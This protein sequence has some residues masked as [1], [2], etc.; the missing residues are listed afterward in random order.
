MIFL[1]ADVE[2]NE[3]CD[4]H[5]FKSLNSSNVSAG[6]PCTEDICVQNSKTT[7]EKS[8]SVN[9]GVHCTEEPE[10][11]NCDKTYVVS[12]TVKKSTDVSGG[13]VSEATVELNTLHL[14]NDDG[15]S[16]ITLKLDEVC[17]DDANEIGNSESNVGK[18]S[19]KNC[20]GVDCERI[21]V[22][23]SNKSLDKKDSCSE[24]NSLNMPTSRTSN[25]KGGEC[26]KQE[27]QSLKKDASKSLTTPYEEECNRARK[28][29]TGTL[30]PRQRPT[31]EDRSVTSCL[32]QF[33][34]QELLTGNNMFICSTCNS[35]DNKKGRT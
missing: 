6:L 30:I 26:C 22:D 21:Q 27:G 32:Y 34:V 28:A 20:S 17:I 18:E 24:S 8:A 15:I 1:D 12:D 29:A 4:V 2:D 5:K 13:N 23:N 11:D 7:D 10:K 25:S 31:V 19:M 14:G 35:Q 3:E 33:T 16:K 9:K